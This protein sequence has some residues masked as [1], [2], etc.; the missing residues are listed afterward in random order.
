MR[1]ALA[2][3]GPDGPGRSPIMPLI[4]RVRTG[5]LLPIPYRANVHDPDPKTIRPICQDMPVMKSLAGMP[6]RLT[7][8]ARR[9]LTC[10]RA[11]A[12]VRHV[13]GPWRVAPAE[14]RVGA[15]VPGSD[16]AFHLSEML[17]RRFRPGMRNR[18]SSERGAVSRHALARPRKNTMLPLTPDLSPGLR[19]ADVTRVLRHYR[20]AGDVVSRETERARS[21]QGA[22]KTLFAPNPAGSG[23]AA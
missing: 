15:V 23:G 11:M 5:K 17:A 4:P 14:D 2:G 1:A 8:R 7:D 3:A 6:T 10:T 22:R 19:I 20:L 12:P 9:D 21:G 13:S 18:L 16:P